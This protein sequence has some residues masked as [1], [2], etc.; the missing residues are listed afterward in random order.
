[1]SYRAYTSGMLK[2]LGLFVFGVFLILLGLASF[3]V[4][5]GH[6]IG[7]VIGIIFFIFGVITVFYSRDRPIME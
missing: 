3:S 2:K 7:Q 5:Q 1:M 6:I 4:S